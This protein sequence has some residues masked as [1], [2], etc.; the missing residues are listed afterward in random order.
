MLTETQHLILFW[1]FVGFFLVIGVIAL[2]AIVGV[3]K[4]DKQ[5][6][7]W[8]VGGFVTGIAGVVFIWAKYQLPLDFFVNLKPPEG[9]EAET[10]VLTS[11]NYEYWDPSNSDNSTP[12]SG[13]VELT[14][15]QKIGW[16]TAKFPYKGMTKSVKLKLKDNK[17]RWWAVRPF[18]PNYNRKGLIKTQAPQK[19]ASTTLPTPILANKAFAAEQEIRF[20][21]YAKKT[22]TLYG[23]TYYKWRVFVDE[24]DQVLN[25][26]AEVQYLLDPTFPEPLQVRTNPN[27]KF[28]VE[29]TG[30]GQ[31]LIQIS[32]KYTDQSTVRTDYYLDFT[33]G[34]P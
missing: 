6:L 9:I 34:W 21:N 15:G 19:D 5:F 20:N 7:K 30:W 11:G 1:V 24:P 33:K 18:Y 29:A 23:K 28:A 27:D 31:F 22:R 25:T 12:P 2:L 14:V 17:G 4:T 10:F 16:W 3:I 26:I 8:A 13:S 32:I